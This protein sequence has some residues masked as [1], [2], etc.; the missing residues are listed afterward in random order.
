M[1]AIIDER[2]QRSRCNDLEGHTDWEFMFRVSAEQ[3]AE[4]NEWMCSHNKAKHG[5]TTRAP[6]YSGAIGGAYTW[7]FTHTTIGMATLVKCSCGDSID[8]SNY[9][10]W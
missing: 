2:R 3:R 5:E 4:A 7:C 10:E 8:L 9:N 1:K 6:R